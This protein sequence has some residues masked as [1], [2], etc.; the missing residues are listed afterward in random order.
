MM[1]EKK[2]TNKNI[3]ITGGAGF[4]GSH[5]VDKLIEN[6]QGGVEDPRICKIG[7]IYYITYSAYHSTI[8]HRV[9][10]SLVTTKDF[11]SF[12]RCGPLLK[13]DMRNVVIFPEKIKGKYYGLFRPNDNTQEHTGGIFKQIKSASYCALN[14][15]I[16][17]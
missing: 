16:A 3:L 2:T 13:T 17:K 8:A 6:E 14:I 9:R 15:I 5:L 1:V 12:K 11:I 7:E 4:I 10:V